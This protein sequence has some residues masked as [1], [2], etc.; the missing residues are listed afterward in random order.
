[1]SDGRSG[2]GEEEEEEKEEEEEESRVFN[3]KG[4]DQIA[5]AVLS[6]WGQA[7]SK[8][9][10]K[11]SR[12]LH[13]HRKIKSTHLTG[14][15][16]RVEDLGRPSIGAISL[17]PTILLSVSSPRAD[18]SAS[19]ATFPL[20]LSGATGIQSEDIFVFFCRAARALAPVPTLGGETLLPDALLCVPICAWPRL[21]GL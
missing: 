9:G 1:M 7:S 4:Y 8:T 20:P 12:T 15:R 14:E 13:G 19:A 3:L 16:G 11:R 17:S 18:V 5:F 21:V 10:D 2:Q 6:M